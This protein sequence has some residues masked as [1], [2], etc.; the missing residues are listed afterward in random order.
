MAKKVDP[1]KAK[2]AK[3][4]KIAIG[5]GVML[6][7]VVAFQGPKTLKLLKGPPTAP[8]AEAARGPGPRT[9]T[10][11]SGASAGHPRRTPS[12]V[13]TVP[14][15]ER[16]ARRLVD[17][18]VPVAAG[19]GQLLSFELFESKDPFEQQARA[20]AIPRSVLPRRRQVGRSTAPGTPKTDAGGEAAGSVVPGSDSGATGGGKAPALRPPP[21][22]AT[23]LSLNGEVVTLDAGGRVPGRR[24]DLRASSRSALDGK[25]IEIGIAGGTYADGDETITLSW[26]S[27]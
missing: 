7:A 10:T 22:A 25:S 12:P 6:L 15:E 26:A 24:P 1:L 9:S 20:D 14:G 27:H 21:A 11:A 13:P 5:L 16:P 4:R 18:D 19:E 8:A 2:D 17:S 3:Q 23:T